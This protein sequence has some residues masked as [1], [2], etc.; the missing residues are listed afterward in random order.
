MNRAWGAKA[1]G[2]LPL[3]AVCQRADYLDRAT[4]VAGGLVRSRLRPAQQ[5]FWLVDGLRL[6]KTGRRS[7]GL[8][9][10]AGGALVLVGRWPAPLQDR[11][12]EFRSVA[13]RW[14]CAG[15]QTAGFEGR[16]DTTPTHTLCTP[17]LGQVYFRVRIFSTVQNFCF[18]FWY[19]IFLYLEPVVQ[20]PWFHFQRVLRHTFLP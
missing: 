20:G 2:V 4:H 10:T 8:L 1:S 13:H 11:S 19:S 18:T 9:R 16:L 5:E 6:C 17:R 15:V 7:L 12:A 3:S 14:R